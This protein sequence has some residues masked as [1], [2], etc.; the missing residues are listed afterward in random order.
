MMLKT[1][2]PEQA[3]ATRNAPPRRT[4]L[5]VDDERDL[6]ELIS[7]NLK[8]NGYEV[9]SA[10]AGDEALTVAE[11][12]LPDLIL[13]DLMMPGLDGTEVARRI[14]ANPLT[15][16]I[17]VIMLTAKGEETDIVVGLTIGADDYVTKPFSMQVLLARLGSVLR[18]RETSAA[19]GAGEMLRVGAL[20]IDLARHEALVDNEPIR[21]TLTEFRLLKGLVEARGRVL[22]RDQL[23]D[24]GMGEGVFITDRAIDVHMTAIRKK[25]GRC[26]GLIHTVRGVGYRLEES[27]EENDERS[28]A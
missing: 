13:L 27:T 4:V 24:K 7:Y 25:L 19:G 1:H 11:R 5:V 28:T 3:V 26:N 9:L 20:T 16:N 23:M 22:T 10:S 15:A 14:R 12:H 18:R 6:V 8:R 21:L 17:P 2:M